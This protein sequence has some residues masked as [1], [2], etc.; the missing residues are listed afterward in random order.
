MSGIGGGGGGGFAPVTLPDPVSAGVPPFLSDK[1]VQ[2]AG[3]AAR[4][5]Q[6]R[7]TGRSGT[8]FTNGLGLAGQAPIAQKALLGS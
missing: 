4:L 7:M 6:Q 2:A 5:A 1:Q 8:V 3:D